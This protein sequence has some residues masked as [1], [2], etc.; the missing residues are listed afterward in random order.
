MRRMEFGADRLAAEMLGDGELL[1]QALER[2]SQIT[3]Q[4]LNEWSWSHPPL[5]ARIA[6]L[7]SPST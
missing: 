6:A 3:G 2:L 4:R 7:R 1:A 5:Q